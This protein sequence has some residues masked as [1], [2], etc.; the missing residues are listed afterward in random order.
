MEETKTTKGPKFIVFCDTETKE[1][2][3]VYA[4]R[5][6]LSMTFFVDTCKDMRKKRK[7]LGSDEAPS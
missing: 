6:V 1:I 7:W 2:D 4:E 3:P 5:V